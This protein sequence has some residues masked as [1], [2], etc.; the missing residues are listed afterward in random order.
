MAWGPFGVLFT[1]KG[2]SWVSVHPIVM[3]IHLKF[4][5]GHSDIEQW[6]RAFALTK[7]GQKLPA[8]RPSRRA[9]ICPLQAAVPNCSRVSDSSNVLRFAQPA[10]FMSLNAFR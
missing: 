2:L 9:G 4:I 1:A 10:A 3:T 8:R 5:K 6:F 7:T